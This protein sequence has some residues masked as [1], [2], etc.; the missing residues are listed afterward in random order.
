M[1]SSKDE[2]EK[3]ICQYI[4]L[5]PDKMYTRIFYFS[6]CKKYIWIKL[7]ESFVP[8]SVLL[9]SAKISSSV[10]GT[11]KKWNIVSKEMGNK[12]NGRYVGEYKKISFK[13]LI[14]IW[15]KNYSNEVS[16]L[17]SIAQKFGE[18]IWNIKL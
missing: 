18:L 7:R 5:H 6:K 11:E 2:G 15:S 17:I 3:K 10:W 12:G 4:T 8:K 13:I 16:Y 9:I 14:I 1:T